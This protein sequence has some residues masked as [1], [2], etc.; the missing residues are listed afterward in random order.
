MGSQVFGFFFVV[1]DI[2][3]NDLLFPKRVNVYTQDN[4]MHCVVLRDFVYSAFFIR[5]EV[6]NDT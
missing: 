2:S 3:N 4:V 6:K 5:S 1:L